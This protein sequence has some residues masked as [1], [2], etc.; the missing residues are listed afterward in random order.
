MKIKKQKPVGDL[1]RFL[2]AKKVET[3]V[4]G[5]VERHLLAAAEEENP[6]RQDILHPSDLCKATVC[7]LALYYRVL[8]REPLVPEDKVRFQ[9]QRIYDEGHEIHHKWQGYLTEARMLEGMWECPSTTCGHRFWAVSPGACPR[10][11]HVGRNQGRYTNMIY[12][13][14]PFDAE[15][16]HLIQG[17]ADGKV[18]NRILEIKSIGAGTVRIE[19]PGLLAQNT[20]KTKVTIDADGEEHHYGDPRTFIDWDGLWKSIKRPLNSHQRQAH[21]YVALARMQDIDVDGVVFL[22]ESKWNQG[23]KEF[24]VPYNPR[25]A[26]PLLEKALDIK[27]AVEKGKPPRCPHNG[28]KECQKYEGTDNNK[29]HSEGDTAPQGHAVGDGRGVGSSS[30]DP[31]EAGAE[32][33]AP[34]AGPGAER[35]RRPLGSRRR[36]ADGA[37]RPVDGLGGVPERTG[38]DG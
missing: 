17:H 5:P 35:A 25:F 16:T 12:K 30:G 23:A 14:V 29:E 27:Y 21:L 18:D 6:R 11:N 2:D 38:S 24:V 15:K 34:A 36:P 20:Y 19:A 8:G 31:G 26:E 7:E 33:A 4:L 10:C 37:V 13:E 3:V 1:R 32:P 28:C 9:L 22:Y